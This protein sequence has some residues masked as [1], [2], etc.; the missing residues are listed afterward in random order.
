MYYA[1]QDSDTPA[2]AKAVIFG[3]LGY[4]ILPVDAVPDF[5]PGGLVDDAGAL[6]SAIT[7]VAAHI[8][9][10]HSRR[11]REVLREWFGL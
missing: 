10:E 8:K 3:A 9:E 11:A 6:A 1:A 2:W 7:V 4:F 5:L